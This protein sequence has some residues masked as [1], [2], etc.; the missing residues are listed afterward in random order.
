MSGLQ[1]EKLLYHAVLVAEAL[2]ELERA[3]EI[4]QREIVEV[5]LLSTGSVGTTCWGEL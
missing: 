1:R 3:F 2:E 4:A 5:R